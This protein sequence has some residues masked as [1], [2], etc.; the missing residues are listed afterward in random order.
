MI[1]MHLLMDAIAEVESSGSR[2]NYPR[3]EAA[4]AP[5]GER[6]TVQGHIITGTGACW[7]MIVAERWARYGMASAASYGPWQILYHT[8]ADLG[9]E[10]HPAYLWDERWS[11]FY[12]DER[13]KKLRASGAVSVEDYA[14]G[15]NGGNIHSTH[16]PQ[17]YID[18]LT[19][20]YARL[21]ATRTA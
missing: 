19:A 3:F 6:Y 17:S 7:N 14:R 8:A 13:L 18:N 15:W 1:V 21:T 16:V 2:N 5:K 20:A 9:Y 4:Y 11:G 10:R 12:V